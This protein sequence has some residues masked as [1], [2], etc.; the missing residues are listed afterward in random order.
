[1]WRGP[2]V[3]SFLVHSF[4]VLSLSLLL[5]LLA[6]FPLSSFPPSLFT[7][8]LT[9]HL[10]PHTH[11]DV[12][13][14]NTVDQYYTSQVQ[15]IITSTVQALRR[16]PERRFTYVEQAYFQRWWAQQNED[17]RAQVRV[18]VQSGQ[19]E[20]SNG[21]WCMHD[22]ATTHYVDM[23][24]QTTLG[25]QAILSEFGPSANPRIG[26]QLDPFGHSATQAALLSAEA[27]FDA[28]FFGRIDYQDHDLRVKS[29][30]LQ[31][32]WRASPSLGAE[33]QVYTEASLDGN[34]NPPDGFCWDW[35]CQGGLGI[36]R[37]EF[38]QD[39]LDLD[40][41]NAERRMADF[42]RAA[43]KM[44]ATHKGTFDTQNI[45]SANTT[46]HHTPHSAPMP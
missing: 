16:N 11:D 43:F 42:M 25:H 27:G 5:P 21:G 44:A 31:F 8:A 12:G 32:I 26:W 40:D 22:E 20:F 23:I 34:Y 28:L 13:W 4:V 1:M 35:G 45:M 2:P 41:Y 46:T 39:R 17:I 3:M 14:L 29:Q 19:L 10:V 18:L 9:V 36:P 6:L 38:V 37:G 33:A 15:H 7:S 24:D 30:D